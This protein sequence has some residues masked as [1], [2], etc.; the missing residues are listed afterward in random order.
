MFLNG[1]PYEKL[2][3]G[4]PWIQAKFQKQT[5]ENKT[6]KTVMT[7]IA[8]Y[9][10]K[11]ETGHNNTLINCT[12]NKY[13]RHVS[14]RIRLR[15]EN[16]THNH[17]DSKVRFHIRGPKP[18]EAMIGKGSSITCAI[19]APA[20][21]DTF[22]MFLDGVAASK[23]SDRSYWKIANFK[24]YN[25]TSTNGTNHT[26]VAGYME[27]FREQHNNTLVNCTSQRY[28]GHASMRIRLRPENST[29]NH[30]GNGSCHAFPTIFGKDLVPLNG[31]NFPV[32]AGNSITL[33]CKNGKKLMGD[34]YPMCVNGTDFKFKEKPR[35]VTPNN[36]VHFK[37]R[38]PKH[39]NALVGKGGEVECAVHASE[40]DDT[41]EM[42]ING[43][44]S[45]KLSEESPWQKAQ[46]KRF[47]YTNK[48]ATHNSTHSTTHSTVIT[49]VSAYME[50]FTDKH[51]N[52]RI[53]C[54]STK[55]NGHAA[56]R[57]IIR[58][59]NSTECTR[60][61][62]WNNCGSKCTKT[63]SNRQPECTKDCVKRCECPSNM[64]WYEKERHCV[65]P[66]QCPAVQ[67]GCKGLPDIDNLTTE[68]K[69]P[70]S[71]GTKIKVYCNDGKKLKG[72]DWI[73]CVGNKFEYG[74]DKPRC[75]TEKKEDDHDKTSSGTTTT[76]SAVLIT[77]A[78]YF[79]L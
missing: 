77:A 4:S 79:Q 30:T 42:Y 55:Y 21:D 11:Y 35:C 58:P 59:A 27:K 76:F 14:V 17:T 24:R 50:K 44:A 78:A 6:N 5:W 20:V 68:T 34:W 53:N 22:E 62:V 46:F 31:T 73:K 43:V 1:E 33:V 9:V 48:N 12:S 60:G 3:T 7:Y 39:E 41:F 37:I 32:E 65:Q 29:H 71:S 69:F 8:G 56:T 2:P 49:G 38:G 64:L 52:T 57:V 74:E 61:Q 18:E 25:Y 23:L 67:E 40:K 26:V 13:Q 36:T 54:T 70:V 66:G 15:A 28:Q 16:S 19:S 45:S 51:N 63:C 75:E 47:S 10:N 72:A